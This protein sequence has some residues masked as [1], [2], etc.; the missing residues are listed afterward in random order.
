[1]QP[2]QDLL[3][4]WPAL[5]VGVP[6]PLYGDGGETTSEETKPLCLPACLP[7]S[8]YTEV[9]WYVRV[10]QARTFISVDSARGQSRDTE[11]LKLP[12]STLEWRHRQVQNEVAIMSH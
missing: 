2:A 9:F 6:A 3:G 8:A 1:M 10:G 11:G 5:R 4:R 12:V 7:A